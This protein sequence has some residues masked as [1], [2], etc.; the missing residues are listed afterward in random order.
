MTSNERIEKLE[1]SLKEQQQ[2]NATLLNLVAQMDEKLSRI[3]QDPP[4][5]SPL[6]ERFEV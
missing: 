4:Q 6:I 2:I 1:E 5:V 3:L